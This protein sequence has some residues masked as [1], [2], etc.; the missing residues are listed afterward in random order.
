[1]SGKNSITGT[2]VVRP[3]ARLRSEMR[4]FDREARQLDEDQRPP[5]KD[6]FPD[7]NAERRLPPVR[8]SVPNRN[9]DRMALKAEAGAALQAAL[10]SQDIGAGAKVVM[11][12]DSKDIDVVDHQRKNANYARYLNFRDTVRK[13]KTKRSRPKKAVAKGK[14]KAARSR[15]PASKKRRLT[16]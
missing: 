6:E 11:T 15:A 3:Q 12:P 1:M 8:R 5:T 7:P 10:D 9:A 4:S 13:G 16:K 14:P 2:K